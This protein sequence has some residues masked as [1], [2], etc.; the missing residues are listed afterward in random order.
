MLC[1]LVDAPEMLDAEE[2]DSDGS[3]DLAPIAPSEVSP[4]RLQ[5]QP[6]DPVPAAVDPA[7]MEPAD[8]APLR[9]LA[10]ELPR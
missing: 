2:R 3:F 7:D 4:V 6:V 1:A 5:P 8:L 10:R 9:G